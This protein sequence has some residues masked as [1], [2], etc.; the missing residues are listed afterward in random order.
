VSHAAGATIVGRAKKK[1]ADGAGEKGPK[2]APGR[3]AK[4]KP[5]SSGN[6]AI[7]AS[8]LQLFNELRLY[9]SFLLKRRLSMADT[10]REYLTPHL[11]AAHKAAELERKQKLG[12]A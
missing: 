7:Y 2:R 3:P 12:E 5:E 4:N 9:G 11:V 1:P 6:A 10:F 8:D